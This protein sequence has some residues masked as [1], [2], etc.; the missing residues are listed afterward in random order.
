M[1]LGVACEGVMAA[2][3]ELSL[4][5]IG[6]RSVEQSCSPNVSQEVLFGIFRSLHTLAGRVSAGL[7]ECWYGNPPAPPFSSSGGGAGGGG[8]GRGPCGLGTSESCVGPGRS[9]GGRG[10]AGAQTP[11]WE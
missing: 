5:S 6:D 9:N 1:V 3:A 7:W 8:A 11:G 10:G 2:V 4:P